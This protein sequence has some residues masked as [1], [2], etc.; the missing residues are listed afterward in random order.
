L[1]KKIFEIKFYET[2]IGLQS[3]YNKYSSIED[4]T[5]NKLVTITRDGKTIKTLVR[6]MSHDVQ[7]VVGKKYKHDTR[8]AWIVVAIEDAPEYNH[9]Y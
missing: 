1:K 6:Q 8:K 4:I 7:L 3:V 9:T 5:M 2:R